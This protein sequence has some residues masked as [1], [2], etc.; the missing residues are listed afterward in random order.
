MKNRL[1]IQTLGAVF[2]VVLL[3]FCSAGYAAENIDPDNDGSQYAYGENVGWL[4][5]EPQGDGGHGVEVTDSALTGYMWG[6]N[7]GWINLTPTEGGVVNDGNGNLSGYAWG[8]NVGWIDFAPA[9]GGV[10]ID[11]CGDFNGTAWGENIGWINF[12]SDGDNPFY[13]RTSWVPP[14]D[15]I[16]PVTEPDSPLLEWYNS[17]VNI[18]LS[19]TDCG[20][21]VNEVHYILDG[22]SEVVTPGS[23]AT[24]GITTEG[25]YTLTYW[26]VDQDGN[27]ESSTGVTIRIDKTPPAI[28]IASPSDGATYFINQDLL[29]DYNVTDTGS[30]VLSTTAPVPKGD[31]IDTSSDG[32]Y[33]FTVSATDLAGNSNSVTHAFTIAYPG[34]IDPNNDGSQYAYAENVGWINFKP[35][36]GPGVTV[37]DSAVTGYAYGENIGWINLSPLQGGVVNDGA[38]NLSGYA[39]GE[40][41]GWINFAPTTGGVTIDVQGNFDGWAWGENIGWIHFQNPSSPSYIVKTAWAPQPEAYQAHVQDFFDE[42]V[43]AETLEGVG[44]GAS[45]DGRLGGVSNMIVVAGELIEDGNI[46]GACEQLLDAFEKTDGLGPPASPPDLVTGDAADDL[47]EKIQDLMTLLECE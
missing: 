10:Y 5:L 15:T 26:S 1:F 35:S 36:F 38:G 30:G 6:E 28:T 12:R 4:N 42:S 9:G 44:P 25:K 43:E 45:A 24:V 34:N 22:G 8:E 17:D 37:T 3:L 11:A 18:T 2:S 21:G 40:N 13:I 31:L 29:A 47:A 33:T 27:I 7:I 39:W 23:T 16:A 20:S 46:P 41:V 14:I 32:S 19:A